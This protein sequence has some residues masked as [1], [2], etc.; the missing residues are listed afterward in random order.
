M[1]CASEFAYLKRKKV[2]PLSKPIISAEMS[3]VN[4]EDA[5]DDEVDTNVISLD[6]KALPNAMQVFHSEILSSAQSARL[7]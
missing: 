2:A 6:F 5:D 3:A 1:N 7:L 4:F